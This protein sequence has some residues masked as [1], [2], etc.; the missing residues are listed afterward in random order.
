MK[1]VIGVATSVN[2]VASLYFFSEIA[3]AIDTKT[4]E[5]A[6]AC[7]SDQKKAM[8]DSLMNLATAKISDNMND[9]QYLSLITRE[10]AT[11]KSELLAALPNFAETTLDN[12]RQEHMSYFLE[13][14]AR[15]KIQLTDYPEVKE[16]PLS[17]SQPMSLLSKPAFRGASPS[18]TDS[19]AAL[20]L[21]SQNQNTQKLIAGVP[22]F[23]QEMMKRK[24][25]QSAMVTGLQA[26]MSGMGGMDIQSQGMGQMPGL[27][28]G[29]QQKID[30]K[31]SALL[32][33]GNATDINLTGELQK[34]SNEN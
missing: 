34:K 23:T 22:D 29:A 16:A 5:E 25:Q 11:T 14:F 3:N 18:Q 13:L 33:M 15:R 2:I 27:P 31:I 24:N 8:S 32:N 1:T 21:N 30:D 9:H 7:S 20:V 4:I 26:T 12:C 19:R 10:W 28:V 17:P 6:A